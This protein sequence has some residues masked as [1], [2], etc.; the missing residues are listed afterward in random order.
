MTN[1]TPAEVFPPGEFIKDELEAR[2]W[3]QI[4]LAE[5]ISKSPRLVSEIVGAK[6]AVTPETARALGE[7]FGTSAQFWMNL[8]SSYRLSQLEDDEERT[9]SRKARLYA[10]PVRDMIKRGWIDGRTNLDVLEHQLIR[11]FRIS[12]I[13]KP[14]DLAYAARKSDCSNLTEVQISWLFRVRQLAEATH[15]S[16]YSKKK[17]LSAIE[18]LRNLL[19][20]PEEIRKVPRILAAA[21]VRFLIVETL[22]HTKVDGVCFWLDKNTPVIAM[23]LRYDRIDN[24]WFVL[25]HEIEHVNQRHGLMIDTELEGDRATSDSPDIPEQERQANKAAEEF[26]VPRHEIDD[27]IARV[28]PI[29]SAV[30]IKRFARRI[31]LHPGLVVGQLHK[32]N[33]LPYSHLRKM[34]VKVRHVITKTAMTDGWE[35]VPQV[36]LP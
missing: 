16:P 28:G 35:I 13:Q 10:Y 34:L 30:G 11:F 27:F 29:Y 15:A 5:I 14:P 36:K 6:R 17:L 31:G 24:F 20:E 33:Q 8:E 22:P 7:A 21:G 1:R 9:I 2:G 25:R 19:H 23:T 4:D 12:S 3:S 32:R 18:E 26:C